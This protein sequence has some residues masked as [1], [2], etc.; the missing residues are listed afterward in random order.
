MIDDDPF[1]RPLK[2]EAPFETLSIEELFARIER[3]KGEIARCEAAIAAKQN[4]KS[5]ADSLFG[6]KPS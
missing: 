2:A 5:A 4:Q 1:A 6:A 3:L